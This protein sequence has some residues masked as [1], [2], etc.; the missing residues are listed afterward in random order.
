M[1]QVL[2][3]EYLQRTRSGEWTAEVLEGITTYVD[4]NKRLV[5]IGISGNTGFRYIFADG[6]DESERLD[7]I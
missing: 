2:T 6:L 1:R 3:S 7:R 4:R 5:A